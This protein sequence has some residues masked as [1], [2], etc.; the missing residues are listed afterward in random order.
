MLGWQ[1]VAA[2][3]DESGKDDAGDNDGVDDGLV[4][5]LLRF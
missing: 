2:T 1:S 5:L 3:K 4:R